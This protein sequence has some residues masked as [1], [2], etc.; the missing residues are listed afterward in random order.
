MS[1]LYFRWIYRYLPISCFFFTIT[2]MLPYNESEIFS[3]FRTVNFV[4]PTWTCNMVYSVCV[5]CLWCTRVNIL[6]R[7]CQYLCLFL[8]PK[9]PDPFL[10]IPLHNQF[11]MF[12]SEYVLHSGSLDHFVLVILIHIKYIYM[13][14]CIFCFGYIMWT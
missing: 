12:R 6:V 5:S 7:F 14:V 13:C 2:C 1:V 3:H 4:L 8:P 11:P 9:T 10:L